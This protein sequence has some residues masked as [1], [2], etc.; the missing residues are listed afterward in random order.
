MRVMPVDESR[1]VV[2]WRQ[3]RQTHPAGT[4]QLSV[5]G[6]KGEMHGVNSVQ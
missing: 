5:T 2:E 1:E 6:V 3:A 4:M